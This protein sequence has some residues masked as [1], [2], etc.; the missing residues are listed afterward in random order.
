MTGSGSAAQRVRSTVTPL[1]SLTG[2]YRH[3]AT[4]L[5]LAAG[6]PIRFKI[7][8]ALFGS[9]TLLD[10]VLV[11]ATLRLLFGTLLSHGKVQVGDR[12]VTA[13]LAIPF[14]VCIG[15]VLWTRDLTATLRTTAMFAEAMV[16]YFVVT[17]SFAHLSSDMIL[18]RAALLIVLLLTGS[19]LSLLQVPGFGPQIPNNTLAGGPEHLAYLT[20]YYGRLSNPFYGLSNDLAS[21]LTLYVCP[22]LAWAVIRGR[23]RYLL[24]S[25]AAF[26]GVLFT[27]SRGVALAT[28]VTGLM[29]LLA[30]QEKLRRWLPGIIL[31][32]SLLLTVGYFYYQLNEA[33]QAYLIDRLAVTTIAVRQELFARAIQLITDAPL[34]GYGAGVV[35]DPLLIDGVHNTYLQQILY[36]G[37]PLGLVCGAALWFLAGRFLLMRSPSANIRVMATAIGVSILAQLALF[38][39]ETSFEAT[40]PKT[41]LYFF[42]GIATVVLVRLKQEVVV[43]APTAAHA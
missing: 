31:G 40:L 3:T 2:R 11:A 21:V 36:Y 5:V 37:I 7:G 23:V 4:I 25:G 14:L 1:P 20:T 32:L 6:M 24:F 10:I 43:N 26:A 22:F 12:R 17:N 38:L 42:M 15:S 9:F 27:L 13:L 30:Q 19:V 28:I 35:V 41:A 33:V 39:V 16:A 34:F 18:A 8:F 29:F